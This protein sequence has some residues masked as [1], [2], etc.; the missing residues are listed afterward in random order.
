MFNKILNHKFVT[1]F[2]VVSFFLSLGGF[3]WAYVSLRDAAAAGPLILHF[4]EIQGI[5]QVGGL[6]VV[7]FMGIFGLLIAVVNGFIALSFDAR[8][9]AFG[10]FIAVL[11]LVFSILL[12]IGFASII[13]VN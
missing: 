4:N 13:G 3:L 6:G 2:S 11:T 8:D 1:A 9:A 10:K 7:V 12:F 5:T